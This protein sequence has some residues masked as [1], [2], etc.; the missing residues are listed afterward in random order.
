MKSRAALILKN[1]V[2]ALTIALGVLPMTSH[3]QDRLKTMPG[4]EQHEKMS[5]L[6]PDS[7][8][9]GALAVKWTEGGKA[10]EYFRDGKSYRYDI[11]TR[12]ATETGTAPADSDRNGRGG[13]RRAGGPERG[14][15]YAS[16]ASPDGKLKAFH[17][18]RNLWLS[19]A[20]GGNEAAVTTDGSEKT[21]TKYAT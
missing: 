5:K 17:R 8:K 13:R 14:R 12:T 11:A 1:G 10:F 18:D 3:A 16:A 20:G 6:I 15:Q 2:V 9:L 7:V 19:D 4:Y 21:R